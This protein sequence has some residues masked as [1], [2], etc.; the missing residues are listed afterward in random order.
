MGIADTMKDLKFKKHISGLGG[1][2]CILC[3]SRTE[4]WTNVDNIIRGFPIQRNAKDT[5]TLYHDLVGAD[6]NI[7]RNRNDF[8]IRKGLTQKPLT[9]SDQRSICITDSYINVTGW[10]IKLLSR[11]HIDYKY[12]VEKTGPLGDP[13]RKAEQRVLNNI[14][15]NT[16]LILEACNKLG[17]R[18]GTSTDGPQ[19]RR[20][21]SEK[22][23][24]S[25]NELPVLKYK[26]H[27][28]ELHCQISAVL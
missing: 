3:I 24:S 15:S 2:D 17:Q 9:R 1:A 21:F 18:S 7:P 25:L 19:G 22:L 14:R 16:G 12:W 13:I 27:L 23:L 28:L 6:G 26:Q 8:E 5:L 11:C 10:F 20:F 4:D